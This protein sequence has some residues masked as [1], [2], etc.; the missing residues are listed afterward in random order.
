MQDILDTSALRA[1]AFTIRLKPTGIHNNC[2]IMND[3]ITNFI[4][5]LNVT[6]KN[7]TDLS[8]HLL[9]SKDIT[10]RNLVHD[11]PMMNV[12]FPPFSFFLAS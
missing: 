12:R 2:F 6:V 4:A 7:V 5:D 9:G 3:L 10:I 11:L 8:Y 1:G